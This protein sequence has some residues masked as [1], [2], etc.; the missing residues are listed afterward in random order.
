M[1]NQPLIPDSPFIYR[2]GMI[3]SVPNG[4]TRGSRPQ[5][6]QI[7]G[8][9]GLPYRKDYGDYALPHVLGFAA[10]LGSAY[11]T[12]FH[13]TFDESYRH[14]PQDPLVMRQDAFLMGL[15]QER[16]LAT[17]SEPWHL[18]IPDEK[19]KHQVLV[20]DT[21][22][23]ALKGVW[24]LRRLFWEFLDSIW[25]GRM[26]ESVEWEWVNI[27]GQKVLTLHKFTPINGDKIGH[28]YNGTPYVLVNSAY[29]D[30]I[31]GAKF[32]YSTVN[33]GIL[34]E[35][36]WRERVLVHHHHRVDADFFDA[37]RAEAIHGV[38]I[39][40]DLFW[41][42]WIRLEWQARISDFVDRVGLGLTVWYYE[43]GNA[44][45]YNNVKKAAEEQSGKM[46]ILLPCPAGQTPGK[47][48][49]VQRIETP[50]SGADLLNR[51]IEP[52][53]QDIERYVVGQEASSKGDGSKGLGNEASAEFQQDTKFNITQYDAWLLADTLTGCARAPGVV[54][55]MKRW[56]F[57][58]ADFPVN[59]VF[60]AEKPQAEKKLDGAKTLFDMKVP[61]KADEVRA[62]GGFSKPGP[63][64]EV[65]QAPPDQLPG[66][67]QQP[68]APREG[69][70]LQNL[71]KR[72]GARDTLKQAEDGGK[73]GNGAEK[74]APQALQPPTSTPV[75][76]QRSVAPARYFEESQP[77]DDD[78]TWTSPSAKERRREQHRDYKRKRRI[79]TKL[80]GK[81]WDHTIDLPMRPE[82]EEL[83]NAAN[84]ATDLIP[85]DPSGH[86]RKALQAVRKVAFDTL[87]K[88]QGAGPDEGES[89]ADHKGNL[90]TVRRMA[91]LAHKA[92]KRLA[93]LEKHPG[94]PKEDYARADSPRQYESHHAPVG[95]ATIDGHFYA[96]GEFIPGEAVAKASPET[97][98]KLISTAPKSN[99]SGNSA[100]IASAQSGNSAS[101]ASTPSKKKFGKSKAAVWAAENDF[102]SEVEI[103]DKLGELFGDK[104]TLADIASLVG[105]PDDAECEVT[106][107]SKGLLRIEV[108]HEAYDAIRFIGIDPKGNLYIKNDE[109]WVKSEAQG[110]GLGADVFGRQV[111]NAVEMGIDF[112]KCHAA[113]ENPQEPKK[114]H[115]G[116]YTW[117][118]FGYDQDLEDFDEFDAAEFQLK[119]AIKKNFSGAKSILDVMATPQGR[120]WWKKNGD[121]LHF[122]KFDLAE[123]SRSRQTFEDYLAER[124]TK[125]ARQHARGVGPWRY[126][127]EEGMRANPHIEEIILDAEQEAALDRAEAKRDEQSEDGRQPAQYAANAQHWI[128]IGGHEEGD[129][130]HA[131]GTRVLIDDD[132]R[133]V[134]GDVPR[135]L[136][137]KRV[138]DFKTLI[139]HH[140]E[141][142]N[143]GDRGQKREPRSDGRGSDEPAQSPPSTG[144]PV[145]R[146]A[147]SS[148]DA[149]HGGERPVEN[150]SADRAT[151]RRVPASQHEV[152]RRLDRFENLFRSRG[153]QQVADWMALLKNHVNAVGTDAA[154]AALG[155]EG[156]AGDKQMSQYEGGWD[157]IGDFAEAY[158]NRNGITSMH[159]LGNQLSEDLRTISSMSP[160]QGAAA[161]R[162]R[163][164]DFTPADPTLP[165]KLE[166]AKKLPGLEKSEDLGVLMGK[167]VSHLSPDV[168]AKLDDVYGQG[169]WIVK[170]YG[171]EAFS[172]Y[173][174]F[175]PQRV[176]QIERDARDAIWGAGEHLAKYGFQ[177]RRDSADRVVGLQHQNGD[178]YD[179]GTP[180][181]EKTIQGDARQWGDRAAQAATSEKAAAIPAGS[182]MAQP[183]FPVVGVSN[184]ERAAGVLF[185]KGQE[186]RVHIVTRNGKAE[187]VPHSTWLK[188]EDLP[189][190]FENED[191][192]AMAQAAVDAINA[193]PESERQNQIYAPDI[194]KTADGFRVVEANPANE[195]G[196]SG[197]LGDNPFIID[198]YVSHLTGREPAHVRFIRKLLS[199]RQ[200]QHGR[201]EPPQ[202]YA[203]A[204]DVSGEARDETGK[205]TKGAG[206][207]KKEKTE[208]VPKKEPATHPG[209]AHGSEVTVKLTKE[210]AAPRNAKGKIE[211]VA[212]KTKLSKQET[213]RVAE[214]GIRAYLRDIE[215]ISDT[216]GLN[217][218]K[219]NESIDLFGDSM[220]PEVKGGLCSNS[221]GAQQWRITFS[222][223]LGQKEQAEYDALTPE[224]QKAWREKK[225]RA[226]LERKLALLKKLSKERGKKINAVTFT[227]IVNPDTRTI[228][229]YRTDGYHQR[230]GWNDPQAKHVAS[231]RYD[232][233]E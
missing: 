26:G 41:I 4:F 25:Y 77:R 88:L 213:G 75:P 63:G 169:Q 204:H 166:E 189:V 3:D 158:L 34:I 160:A 198:S 109:F 125:P 208:I 59:F 83:I 215:G 86:Y 154:L 194:V 174:I 38:G 146:E 179:F 35:G 31:P 15:L 153:Q 45:S 110:Q 212:V 142:V 107:T 135:E 62:A 222:M 201:R 117:P 56:S 71:M 114:P 17:A 217:S 168:L 196:S 90:R 54:S 93:E 40:S 170:S 184:E 216:V 221:G 227:G 136:H 46:N 51:I 87:Q 226:C 66:G 105:A 82:V 22:T 43:Q 81:L 214:A 126:D 36:S 151:A 7:L 6:S 190:V 211:P 9:D 32:I 195:T 20:R 118:R 85:N 10:I 145:A 76:Q 152:N 74:Q 200:Q 147:P 5:T 53:R 95:G 68:G 183:A 180:E 134:G 84:V 44:A 207:G 205:W 175:F 94:R 57:P 11:K 128:T 48:S 219:P 120:E 143:G 8:A 162:G 111:E 223:E 67:G 192:L 123:G 2:G 21:L 101:I 65:V 127:R 129:E 173:G 150:K 167:P 16:K 119:K 121:D 70:R 113:K 218:G 98:E 60:G 30:E 206:A 172:G 188:K 108:E 131:G 106:L 27:D 132:G 155:A 228:D 42:N 210:M 230:I 91:E 164:G 80:T 232:H 225:Q 23:K 140:K 69:G 233:P 47:G 178:H 163:T 171:D 14:D 37:D 193:L 116:Y 64:D 61:L 102:A 19:D 99:Q 115:N 96:G 224:Q 58:W 133:I 199:T 52:L 122:A 104:A 144:G 157:S 185:K 1:A 18:E 156:N 209:A 49:G 229:I 203:A 182:F 33:K 29:S 100:P 24:G 97:R 112:I 176:A 181:Y 187:V 55:I 78:G 202:Q 139:E 220:A 124:A 50:A 149:G 141:R 148:S 138:M 72:V 13:Q 197:Y 186:A 92:D 103:H 177:L 79:P 130:K 12:Y 191:T 73:D 161:P 28:Q 165:N 89:E 137:G 159:Q 231:V 39:R